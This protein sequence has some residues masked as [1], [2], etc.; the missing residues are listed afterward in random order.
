MVGPDMRTAPFL[1]QTGKEDR[2]WGREDLEA[3]GL[4][5]WQTQGSV[6]V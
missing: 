5:G 4:S 2:V 6:T 1:Q 3:T